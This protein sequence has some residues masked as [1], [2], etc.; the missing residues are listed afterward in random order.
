MSIFLSLNTIRIIF[1]LT[2]ELNLANWGNLPSFDCSVL[3]PTHDN[4]LKV[5]ISVSSHSRTC[6]NRW[7]MAS[8]SEIWLIVDNSFYFFQT[9]EFV[10]IPYLECAV[11][12]STD[13]SIYRWNKLKAPDWIHMRFQ[14]TLALIHDPL[15]RLYLFGYCVNWSRGVIH[16]MTLFFEPLVSILH[17]NDLV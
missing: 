14:T 13:Q 6:Q 8:Q 1:V 17:W 11:L 2:I 3:R 9:V 4:V 5:S 10:D 7:L 15:S 12:R 16:L